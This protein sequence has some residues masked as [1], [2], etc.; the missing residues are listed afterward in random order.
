MQ[1]QL[2]RSGLLSNAYLALGAD[3]LS[4]TQYVLSIGLDKSSTLIEGHL[5]CGLAHVQVMQEVMRSNLPFAVVLE[6]DV[7]LSTDITCAISQ[8]L[9]SPDLPPDWDVI[10][11]EPQFS[12]NASSGCSEYGCSDYAKACVFAWLSASPGTLLKLDRL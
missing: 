10:F 9:L 8:A 3:A 5:A 12:M 7:E 1:R 2:A 11:L 6:D 4:L